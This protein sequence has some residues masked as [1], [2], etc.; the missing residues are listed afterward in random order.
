MLVFNFV[1]GE[2]FFI[3]NKLWQLVFNP[4]PILLLIDDKLLQDMVW[5]LNNYVENYTLFTTS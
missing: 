2:W 3:V 5:W 1:S 4:G